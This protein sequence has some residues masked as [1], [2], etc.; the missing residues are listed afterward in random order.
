MQGS[1]CVLRRLD[2]RLTRSLHSM[3]VSPLTTSLASASS[4]AFPPL[5]RSVHART[6]GWDPLL[7]QTICERMRWDRLLGFL[8]A[9]VR[10]RLLV[11][12]T[13]A[14]SVRATPL[15]RSTALTCARTCE[16]LLLVGTCCGFC[17]ACDSSYKSPRLLCFIS[18]L[19]VASSLL[20][21][22]KRNF[23]LI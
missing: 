20:F 16:A 9:L 5:N 14:A 6:A 21:I 10:S 23:T 18:M 13:V 12:S 3:R 19:G 17:D 8:L 15:N 11:V 4:L 22:K 2:E 1:C 7:L